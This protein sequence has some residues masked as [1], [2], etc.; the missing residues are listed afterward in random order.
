[1]IEENS[2]FS[3]QFGSLYTVTLEAFE[4]PLDLLLHLI[5]KNEVDI[6]NI[7]IAEITRQ[8][9]AYIDLLKEL[10]LDLAGEFLVIASTLVQIKSRM[11][12]P[13]TPVDEASAEE[14]EDPRAE[15]VKRLLEY[16]KY[17]EA[18]LVLDRQ[19]LVGRDV[20]TRKIPPEDR[21]DQPFDATPLELDLYQLVAAFQKLLA[22]VPEI[23]LHEVGADTVQ[24]ADRMT[25]ILTLLQTYTTVCFDD[26][27]PETFNREYIV[28]SFLAILELCRQGLLHLTQPNPFAP[29]WLTTAVL[30]TDRTEEEG[31]E[32]GSRSAAIDT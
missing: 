13:L 22:R 3:D 1:M 2:L 19:Q 32:H 28:A 21:I 6:Y 8:Y 15:L 7:P 29:I 14:L 17:K 12:L 18:A 5:K 31:E 27:F 26:L 9:L 20:F 24:I 11:L 16:Q 30:E 25:E 10:N 23:S 4:G